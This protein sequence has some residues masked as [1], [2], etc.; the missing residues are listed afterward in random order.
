M[1]FGGYATDSWSPDG[2]RFGTPKSFLFSV[3]LDRKI[4][5]HGR[6]RDHLTQTK[7]QVDPETN[8]EMPL[9]HDCLWATQDKIGFGIKDLVLCGDFTRCVSELENSYGMGLTAGSPEAKSFLAGA[10]VFKAEA[11]EV[12][13]IA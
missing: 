7:P 11:V 5:F 4:P 10:E 12:W 1:V 2:K 6:Q 8:Y 9:Q 3:S 13:Q